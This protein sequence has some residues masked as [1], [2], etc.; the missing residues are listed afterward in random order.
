[1][2]SI[3]SLIS[4]ALFCSCGG[5]SNKSVP[6]SAKVGASVVAASPVILIGGSSIG[7]R[8]VAQK[9]AIVTKAPAKWY[10]EEVSGERLRTLMMPTGKI[11]GKWSYMGSRGDH[12]FFSHE[13]LGRDIYRVLKTQYEVEDSFPLTWQNSKWRTIEITREPFDPELL[14]RFRNDGEIELIPLENQ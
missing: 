8:K 12:H 7:G 3:F 1:M 13:I 5:H 11:T 6:E 14:E 2:K 9:S 10:A 4:V